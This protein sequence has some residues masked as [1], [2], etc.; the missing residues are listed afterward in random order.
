MKKH[1]KYILD[2]VMTLIMVLLMKIAFVG[3]LWHE[4]LGLGIFFLFLIHNILNFNY[5]KCII[6]KFFSDC[7]KPKMK[8]GIVLDVLLS[9]VVTGIVVT[10]IM[11]SKEIFP[12]GYIGFVS[13]LHHSLSYLALI[14][15]SVHVGLHWFEIMGA[16]RKIFKLENVNRAR[17]Y[18]LRIVTL[19]IVFFG[20]KGSFNQDVAGKLLEF[21]ETGDSI[22]LSDVKVEGYS[23]TVVSAND[24]VDDDV[25]DVDGNDVTATPIV[26]LEEYLSNLHCNGCHKHCPLSAPQ[27]N[28]G[29]QNALAAT[30]EYNASKGTPAVTETKSSDDDKSKTTNQTTTTTSGSIEDYLS[31]LYCNGCSRHCPLSAPQCG[32][33]QQQAVEAT[34]VFYENGAAGEIQVSIGVGEVLTDFLPMMGMYIAGAHY[35][36]M[37]PKYLKERD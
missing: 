9:L 31:K 34:N 13:T 2:T 27:C 5:L 7:V 35:L 17:T 3:L 14:L 26:S 18:F 19:F 22:D 10:G 21:N 11:V 20:I 16:F 37:I 32:V 30:E 12:F 29:Q 25:D 1:H 28:I 36:V 4:I 15:I 23:S 8:V 33:G 6:K 24:D